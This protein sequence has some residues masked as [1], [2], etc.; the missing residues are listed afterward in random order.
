[1]ITSVTT[2]LETLRGQKF[3]TIYADPPWNYSDQN[4]RAATS[5]HYVT[6]NPGDICRLPVRDLAA[7]NCHLHL[8]A[9]ASFLPD[10]LEVLKAW[11]FRYVTNFVWVKRQMGIGHYWRMS[12]EHL[13]LGVRGRMSA[14]NRSQW[15]WMLHDRLQHS[16]KPEQVRKSVELLSTGPYLELFGRRVVRGGWTVFGNQIESL[17]Q[18]A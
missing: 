14:R 13:L 5:N 7:D 15:S 9:T 10:G 4:T 12:H 18:A 11:G 16:E 3:G 17:E 2:D 8:W 1:M 6:M